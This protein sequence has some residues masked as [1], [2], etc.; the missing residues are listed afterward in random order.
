[1]KESINDKELNLSQ[2]EKEE[3][4][5]LALA[6]LSPED[7]ARVKQMARDLMDT[8]KANHP[9]VKFSLYNAYEVLSAIGRLN[10]LVGTQTRYSFAES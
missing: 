6:D 3:L 9:N 7:D 10:G 5:D 1:M 8:M 4:F 2:E